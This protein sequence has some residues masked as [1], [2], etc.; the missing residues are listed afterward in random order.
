MAVWAVGSGASWVALP[1]HTAVLRLG[2][3]GFKHFQRHR[4]AHRSETIT[5]GSDAR[6]LT[7]E[8]VLNTLTTNSAPPQ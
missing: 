2:C 8:P 1:S 5:T 7:A 3:R 6:V 4:A